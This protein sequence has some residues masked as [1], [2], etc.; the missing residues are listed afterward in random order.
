MQALRVT[1]FT[2]GSVTY[3]YKYYNNEYLW[4][5]EQFYNRMKHGSSGAAM[6]FFNG[7]IYITIGKHPNPKYLCNPLFIANFTRKSF[8]CQ[9]WMLKLLMEYPVQLQ[10]FLLL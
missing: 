3:H 2:I 1:P 5:V 10:K 4:Q 8:I 6:A 7:Q 9:T